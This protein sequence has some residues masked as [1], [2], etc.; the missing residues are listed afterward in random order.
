MG[1]GGLFYVDGLTMAAKCGVLWVGLP[2]RQAQQD[3]ADTREYRH[4]LALGTKPFLFFLLI[5]VLIN[6]AFLQYFSTLPLITMIPGLGEQAIGILLGVNGLL[7]FLTEMPLIKWW[8]N[9]E[10]PPVL[11]HALQHIPVRAQFAV[12]YLV[13][14]V[15]FLWVGMCVMSWPRC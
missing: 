6:I 2:R 4:P 13:P 7:I 10:V 3:D 12:L 9:L 1:Y 15:A 5:Q 14:T 8:N 11:H